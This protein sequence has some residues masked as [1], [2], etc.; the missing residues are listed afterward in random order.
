MMK[1]SPYISFNGNCAEAVAL[2]EKAFNSKA[3][4]EL[5]ENAMPGVAPAGYVLDAQLQ[6]GGDTV[7][8]ND[9]MPN[10][11]KADI[12]GN[13][14]ITIKFDEA[15]ANAM[16]AGFDILKD[17]GEVSMDWCEV[18]WSKRF[19]LVTDKFGTRWNF[20]QN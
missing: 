1:V 16:I 4:I 5:Y 7:M 3:N 12:G 15:D 18:P 9:V 11:P 6:I 8:L 17:G 2:Y 10:M 19:S 20:C 14:M 13:I